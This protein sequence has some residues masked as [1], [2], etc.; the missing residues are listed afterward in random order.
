MIQF[1]SIT[2]FPIWNT[3]FY[4]VLHKIPMLYKSLDMYN[5]N[6]SCK[7]SLESDKKFLCLWWALSWSVDG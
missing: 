1:K 6:P 4:E 7:H 5:S 3:E 2:F